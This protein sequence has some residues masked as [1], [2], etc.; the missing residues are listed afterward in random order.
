VV[1]IGGFGGAAAMIVISLCIG[2]LLQV[3]RNNYVPVF[4]IAGSAYMVALL[5]IH[6]LVPRL[7]AVDIQ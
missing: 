3:S 2:L 1:G 6:S 5:I 7:A 4:M